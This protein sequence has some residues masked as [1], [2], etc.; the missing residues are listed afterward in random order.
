MK[1]VLLG[2]LLCSFVAC[3]SS[4]SSDSA[5]AET[6]TAKAVP[7]DVVLSSPTSSTAADSSIF[8]K[9]FKSLFKAVGDADSDDYTAKREALQELISAAGECSF[10]LDIPTVPPPECYGPKINYTGHINSGN[11]DL[12]TDDGSDPEDDDGK[13]PVGDTGIWNETEGEEA[14]AA[15]KMNQLVNSVAAKVDNAIKLFGAMACAGKKAGLDLPAV[16]AEVDLTA[17]MEEHLDVE[18]LTVDSAT[19]ERLADDAEG[20]EVY[21]S[22]VTFTMSLPGNTKTS[23]IILKHIPTADDNS[24]YQ[25]KLSITLENAVRDGG[26]CPEGGSVD[27]GTILYAKSSDTDVKYEVNFAEFCGADA[28]PLDES[29]NVD[30]ADKFDAGTNPTGWANNWNYA[31]FSINPEESTGSVSFAWQAGGQDGATRVFNVATTQEDD[32]D[33]TGTAY[34]GYGPDIA[35]D[36]GRGTITKMICNW[37]GPG[38]SHTGVELAQKQTLSRA[39][40]ETVWS[41]AEANIT[42]ALSNSCDAGAGDGFLYEAVDDDVFAAVAGDSGDELDFSNNRDTDGAAVVNNLVPLDEVDFVMPTPPSDV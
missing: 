24:T 12:D 4:S 15:A 23:T 42:Y 41:S 26:N 31:L 35:T 13:L 32:G 39:E 2:V 25:G 9:T 40:G 38:N 21:Q 8:V 36:E 17:A 3:G 27:G 34:F 1:K 22:T 5:D 30:A 20:N 37:A 14:C 18:L 11:I 33:A 7:S 28:E 29:N 19:L 16:G 6:S 10:T